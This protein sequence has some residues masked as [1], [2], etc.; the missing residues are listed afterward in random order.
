[1]VIFCSAMSLNFELMPTNQQMMENLIEKENNDVC[2][3]VALDVCTQCKQNASGQSC[4]GMLLYVT[5]ICVLFFSGYHI[6]I[7]L[8]IHQDQI[9]SVDMFGNLCTVGFLS[10]VPIVCSWHNFERLTCL[11]KTSAEFWK[12]L[13]RYLMFVF[14][15]I[16][17]T[18]VYG[19]LRTMPLFQHSLNSDLT[20]GQYNVYVCVFSVI[21]VVVFYWLVKLFN[22][23][24]TQASCRPTYQNKLMFVRL[25][26]L[27]VGLNVGSYVVCKTEACD[28]HPHHW[29]YGYSLVILSTA[30]MDNWFDFLLQGIFWTFVLESQWNGRTVYDRFFI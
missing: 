21:G 1:M 23:R 10:F 14:G 4:L 29:F 27:N 8:E 26:I 16:S 6:Y 30:L 22:F 7:V 9:T 2:P 11:H 5:T 17:T 28:Y 12:G 25:F 20:T 19:T 13:G 18:V 3:S 15:T 24:C